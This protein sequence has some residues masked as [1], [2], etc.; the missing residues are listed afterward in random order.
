MVIVMK[1][2]DCGGD[3]NTSS[4]PSQWVSGYFR[5]CFHLESSPWSFYLIFPKIWTDQSIQKFTFKDI[6]PWLLFH[7]S[8]EKKNTE[9]EG[10]QNFAFQFNQVWY[11][12]HI[13]WMDSCAPY[14]KID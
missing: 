8:L 5:L 14:V 10:K 2:D 12:G 7:D 13:N 6:K 3:E 4:P 9:W 1:D 11:C